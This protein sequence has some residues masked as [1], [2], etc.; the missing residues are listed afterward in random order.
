MVFPAIE[1]ASYR[2]TSGTAAAKILVPAHTSGQRLLIFSFVRTF[3]ITSIA[4]IG[5]VSAV[6]VATAATNFSNSR[7]YCYYLDATQDQATETEYD[8]TLSGAG[9]QMTWCYAVDNFAVDAPEGSGRNAQSATPQ[10]AALTPSWDESDCKWIAFAGWNSAILAESYPA[11]YNEQQDTDSVS[12]AGA[13]IAMRDLA[14]ATETPGPFTIASSLHYATITVAVRGG[15]G[16][17]GGGGDTVQPK[18]MMLV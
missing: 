6:Q 5:G 3:S 10:P 15:E 17:G 9:N 18:A 14:A 12:L 13:G 16:G 11:N 7:I 2:E 1:A 8:M 4:T